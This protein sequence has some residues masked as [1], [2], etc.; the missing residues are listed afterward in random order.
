MNTRPFVKVSVLFFAATAAAADHDDLLPKAQRSVAEV[1]VAL[2]QG[3]PEGQHDAAALLFEDLQSASIAVPVDAG[4]LESRRALTG[5]VADIPT[6]P[7]AP[8]AANGQDITPLFLDIHRQIRAGQ[9]GHLSP[10]SGKV[11]CFLVYGLFGNHITDYMESILQRLR[12]MGLDA[13]FIAIQTEGDRAG[14]LQKIQNAVDGQ[15]QVVLIG[16]SRGG[17]LVHD[18]YRLTSRAS[19]DKVLKLVL[20]QA[21]LRG[22]PIADWVLERWYTRLAARALGMLYQWG[23]VMEATNELTVRTRQEIMASLPP[24]TPEDL[25]K[26]YTL[27]SSFESKVND[28]AHK[29]ML[30][31]HG[32]IKGLTGQDNDGLVPTESAQVPGARTIHLQDFDHEDS[33][34]KDAGWI[35]R[36]RGSR[37]NDDLRAGDMSEALA[38][39]LFQP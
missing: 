15:S 33:A 34:L 5:N 4:G 24:F 1:S 7:S 3:S 20:M 32:I 14:N 9:L 26:V 29:D 23:N 28:G 12:A 21:P 35:K 16:H 31:S 17:I 37:P 36:L 27:S 2:P 38:H 39:V 13:E 25:N 30:T 11:K 18:W 19:Q 10:E 6:P 22:T 8:V